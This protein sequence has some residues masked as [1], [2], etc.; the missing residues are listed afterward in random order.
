MT[1]RKTITTDLYRNQETKRASLREQFERDAQEALR[2]MKTTGLGYELDD[3]R[4][5]FTK[6]AAFRKGE[7]P[8]PSRPRLTKI[9]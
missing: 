3:A 9:I 4:E 2:V 6:L 5:Y 7:G 8:K 1:D